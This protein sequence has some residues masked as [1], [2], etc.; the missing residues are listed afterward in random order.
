MIE[1][2][3]NQIPVDN[4]A[5]IEEKYDSENLHSLLAIVDHKMSELLHS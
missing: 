3:R 2:F 1:D 4:K 5:A